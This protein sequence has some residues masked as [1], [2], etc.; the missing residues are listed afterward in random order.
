MIEFLEELEW[1][2]EADKRQQSKVRYKLREIVIIVLFATFADADDWVEIGMFAK[3]HES[4]LR[5][6]LALEN[7]VPS[8][9]TIQRAMAMVSPELL[10]QIQGQFRERMNQEEGEKLKKVLG[11]NGEVM[12]EEGGKGKEEGDEA[13][14]VVSIDGKTMRGNKRNGEKPSHI[15]SAWNGEDGFCL[16]QT[17]VDE[18]SNEITAIPELLDHISIRKQVVTIDAMG[19]QTE[20]AKKIRL[21]GADYVLALKKNHKGPY[22]EVEEYFQDADFLKKIREAGGYKQTLEK[23]HGRKEVREYYQTEDVKWITQRC[24]WTGLKSIGMEKKTLEWKDGS[25]S[26]EYRYFIS[27]LK[28][29]IALFSRAVRQHWSVEVMHWHLDVTFREDANHTIDKNAAQNL[30]IIRKFCLSVLKLVEIIH[31]RVSMKKKR[32]A[33][34]HDTEK[35]LETVLNF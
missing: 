4:Y 8:H 10:Q 19:T 24:E 21:K 17:A 25:V 5:K 6:Y 23:A 7:G 3:I 34:A 32:F 13:K 26:V 20:I 31:P 12:S 29:D 15:V 33:I 30:N 11:I 27:S 9:D 35:Y 2:E 28:A 22:Y 16:G 18:K 1:I 14:A